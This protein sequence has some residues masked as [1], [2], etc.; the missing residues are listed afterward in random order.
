MSSTNDNTVISPLRR[1]AA[2]GVAYLRFADLRRLGIV[3]NRE[4]L[5]RRLASGRLPKPV[6]LDAAS[7]RW[8][9]DELVRWDEE[10]RT[11]RQT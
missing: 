7:P 8:L 1:L 10:N 5:R 3:S 2:D 11:R 9:V 6:Y 4:T